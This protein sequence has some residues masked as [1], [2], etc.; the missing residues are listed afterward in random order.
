MGEV[1]AVSHIDKQILL[2]KAEGLPSKQIAEIAKLSS[3]AIDKRVER[4]M[5]KFNCVSSLHL[6]KTMKEQGY[7]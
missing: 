7:I 1:I 2:M 4:L 6:Y 5:K 3:D